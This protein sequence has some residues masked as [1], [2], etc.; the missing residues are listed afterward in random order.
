MGAGPGGNI[1][2]LLTQLGHCG[3]SVLSTEGP[4]E[5]WVALRTSFTGRAGQQSQ[6]LGR[7]VVRKARQTG[8]HLRLHQAKLVLSPDSKRH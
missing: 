6:T 7:Q 1:T 4:Q 8:D 2:Y 3:L 5:S